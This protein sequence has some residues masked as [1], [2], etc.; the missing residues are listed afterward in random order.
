MAGKGSRKFGTKKSDP[1]QKRYV[2]EGRRNK[3]KILRLKRTIRQ[4]P[5]NTKAHD[6]LC[7]LKDMGIS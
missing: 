3:N 1:C 5:N 2:A 7:A 6:R 4:Q